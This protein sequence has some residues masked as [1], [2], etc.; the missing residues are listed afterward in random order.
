MSDL[1]LYSQL[2]HCQVCIQVIGVFRD[3]QATGTDVQASKSGKNS[4]ASSVWRSYLSKVQSQFPDSGMFGHK[5]YYVGS[6]GHSV[7]LWCYN[8]I[9]NDVGCS[10]NYLGQKCGPGTICSV[11]SS[12]NHDEL[13]KLIINNIN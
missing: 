1:F 6:I 5:S 4:V 2:E 3:L 13:V 10:E 8:V 11:S 7:D 9:T 12:C